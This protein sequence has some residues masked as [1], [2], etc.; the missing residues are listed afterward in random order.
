MNFYEKQAHYKDF[1]TN[2]AFQTKKLGEELAKK[3]L[4]QK[5]AKSAIVI[6]LEGGL[7]TGKTTFLQGFAKG[8]GIRQ[9]IT[10]PTF[11]IIK[12]YKMQ[13]TKRKIQNFYHIDCYRISWVRE[14]SGLGL[15]EI[16]SSPKN[17]IAIEWADRIQKILPRDR[18]GLK[19]R[20]INK[21][22]RKVVVE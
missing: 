21:N 15:K 7:G 4:A 17:I 10:S 6:A 9:R 1:L 12:K 2:S 14:I 8:L 18:I 11:V 19:F 20:F 3:I 5:P 22:T 16:I 13:D